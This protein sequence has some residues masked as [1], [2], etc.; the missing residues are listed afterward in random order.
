MTELS[1]RQTA[2][3]K[4]MTEDEE[5][6]RH[7][8]ELLLNR[9]D[10]DNFFDALAGAG[11]FHPSRNLAQSPPSSQVITGFLTGVRLAT[12]KRWRSGRE[13]RTI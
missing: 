8:F 2:F 11:L 10:F 9:A 12:S 7:G 6:E 4:T 5:Y 13:N 3:I 1:I